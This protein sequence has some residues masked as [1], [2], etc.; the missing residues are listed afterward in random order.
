MTDILAFD[1]PRWD[2]QWDSH[3]IG[4]FSC[5][6]HNSWANIGI[7]TKGQL[8]TI[9]ICEEAQLEFVSYLIKAENISNVGQLP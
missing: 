1:D 9:I 4:L 8:F 3:W 5:L 6:R 7:K 2:S